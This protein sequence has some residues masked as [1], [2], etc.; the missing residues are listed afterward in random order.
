MLMAERY[1]FEFG[2]R[3]L[4][5]QLVQV[6]CKANEIS[7]VQADTHSKMIENL[8]NLQRTHSC[9]A[10]RKDNVGETRDAD[11]LVRAAA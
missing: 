9:G 1:C 8:G 11:G 6:T 3:R 5:G 2:V 10:L 7:R 4:D